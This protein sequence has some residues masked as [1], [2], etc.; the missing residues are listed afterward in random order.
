MEKKV[1]TDNPFFVKNLNIEYS[2]QKQK[3]KLALCLHTVICCPTFFQSQIKSIVMHLEP[4][5]TEK[6]SKS[7]NKNPGNGA[8]G[9]QSLKSIFPSTEFR[10]KEHIYN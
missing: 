7:S 5:T 3:D 9:L 6:S 2:K 8:T 10:K 1:Y 4:K